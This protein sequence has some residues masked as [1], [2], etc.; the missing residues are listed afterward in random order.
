MQI[1]SRGALLES[2]CKSPEAVACP[3]VLRNSKEAQMT[4]IVPEGK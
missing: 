3:G 1:S 2:K 4:G